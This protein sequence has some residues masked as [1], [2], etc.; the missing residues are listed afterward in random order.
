MMKV[1]LVEP[2][3]GG[4]HRSWAEGYAATSRHEVRPI[5][6]PGRWWLP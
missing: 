5:T 6:H 2:Y 1:L 4:S 3:F